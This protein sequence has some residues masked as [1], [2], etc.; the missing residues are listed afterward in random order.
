MAYN[1]TLA[2]DIRAHLSGEPGVSEKEMFGGISFMVNGNLA[3]GVIGDELMIRV[4][5][6]AHE[7]AV[8]RPGTRTFDMGAR[9]MKGW[10]SVTAEGFPTE[11]TFNSWIDQGV[12]F[13]AG[14]PPK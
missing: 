13:A 2:D 6:E 8:S 10:V 7:A 12:S 3:V 4:G 5:K 14:L 9:P 11:E 1:E